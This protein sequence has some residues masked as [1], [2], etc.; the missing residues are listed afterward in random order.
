MKKI[1]IDAIALCAVA[2]LLAFAAF[3]LFTRTV[4]ASDDGGETLTVESVWLEVDTLHIQ[5]TDAQTGV[6]QT[7]ELN[8]RDYAGS[9]D[10]YVSVQAIDRDGNKS[11]TILFKNPYYDANAATP[12]DSPTAPEQ[13]EPTPPNAAADSVSGVPGESTDDGDSAASGARPFTPDGVGSVLDNATDGDGKEFFSVK[14]EDGNTFYLIVDRQRTTD[15]VYLLNAVTEEDLASLAKPGNGGVGSESAIPTAPPQNE[16]PA[17]ELP[18]ESPSADP[19]AED[20][21]GGIGGG[22][23]IFIVIAALAVGGA[24]Y[25]FKIVKPKKSARDED[26]EP[27]DYGGEYD[28]PEDSDEDDYGAPE[29]SYVGEDG[30]DAE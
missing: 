9:G 3:V 27:D 6:N 4:F 2:F 23:L 7:L 30:G 28:A 15:N 16:T 11:N 8:L 18:D 25:Y 10:E 24:G 29:D 13:N 22:S 21:N 5:V 12:P 14:T 20:G 19:P 17:P 26:E 1:K